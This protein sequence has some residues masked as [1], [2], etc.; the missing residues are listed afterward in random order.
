M[1]IDKNS[2]IEATD[3]NRQLI[4]MNDNCDK[5]DY[6]AAIGC[7]AIGGIIDIFWVGSPKDSVLTKFTDAQVDNMVK[8]FAKLTGWNPRDGKENS[9]QSGIGYLEKKFRVNYDQRHTADVGGDFDMN[10]RNHHML[11]LS[12]APDILGLFF[13]ILNQFTSTSTFIAGGG[14]ITIRTDTFELEGSN[15]F[16]KIFCGIANWFGHIMSDIA[17]SSGSRGNT[18]RGSGVVIPFYELFGLCKFGSFNVGKDKQDLA[19]IAIRAFQ[20]GYDFRHG[21]AMAIPVVLTDL[22]IRLVWSIRRYFQYRKPI[23]ACI[24]VGSKHPDLRI[25][26][27]FGHGTLCAI[28]G[29]DAGIRSGGNALTFFLR[30]NL[31]AWFRFS[32]LVL[33]EICIRTG[34]AAPLEKEL[35]AFKRLNEACKLY[36]CELEK[37]DFEKFKKEN[38]EYSHTVELLNDAT[39]N[40]NLNI[41]LIEIYEDLN[42][43][44]PWEGDLD[45]FMSDKSNKMVFE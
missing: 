14:I 44:K 25:M 16:S 29:I 4:L 9:I 19:T 7:G 41:A 24:P 32:T 30:L 5:Y 23:D 33:R 17:G 42:I 12:H 15:F 18:G 27:L 39:T 38:E 13:S 36:L 22:S 28:D 26:L 10:T 3:D 43:K 21:L 2:L 45:E 31:I 34:L 6:M 35:E 1:E 8:R 11:S 40:E 20:E 37:I